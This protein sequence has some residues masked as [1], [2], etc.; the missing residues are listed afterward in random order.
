VSFKD[1]PDTSLSFVI[2]LTFQI[3]CEGSWISDP[4]WSRLVNHDLVL[5]NWPSGFL[6]WRFPTSYLWCVGTTTSHDIRGRSAAK[7]SDRPWSPAQ[8]IVQIRTLF[9]FIAER[10]DELLVGQG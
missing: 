5:W 2:R 3:A 9:D 6:T 1:E 10:E 8:P 7:Q 4:R